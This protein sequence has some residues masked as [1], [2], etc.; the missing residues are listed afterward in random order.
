MNDVSPVEEGVPSYFEDWFYFFT[1][2]IAVAAEYIRELAYI[3]LLVLLFE[4]GVCA[5]RFGIA[6][7]K[8]KARNEERG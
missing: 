2:N 6:F 7:F 8:E 5:Y 1:H 4:L 3:A